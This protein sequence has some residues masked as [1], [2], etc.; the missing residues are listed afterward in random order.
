[1]YKLLL[2]PL[3]TLIGFTAVSQD[4][5]GTVPFNEAKQTFPQESKEAFENW[6]HKR[7]QYKKNF[8]INS[9]QSDLV[10]TIPVVVHV[11]HQGESIGT[12]S[13]IPD[14]QI[15]S[16]IQ[17][18][19][20]D[21]RRTNE[22]ANDTPLDFLPFAAD[23]RIEFKLAVRDPE[24]LP[25]NGINRVRGSRDDYSINQLDDLAHESYWD[26][27][28]YFNI[29]VSDLSNDYIGY[30][31]FPLSNLVGLNIEQSND[32]LTDG[33]FIDYQY[34]GTGY[35]TDDFSRGRTVTHEVGHWLGLRHI[36][37]DASNC[38]ADD[39]CDDTPLQQSSTNPNM[40]C[41][42]AS[43]SFSCTTTDMTQNYMDY[44][45]DKCMNLFTLDQKE[46]MRTV[47]ENS[48]RRTVL[49]TSPALQE[50]VQVA[51]D[52]GIYQIIEP[53]SGN[54]D[55]NITPTLQVKNYGTNAITSFDV[56]LK[57]DGVII[58]T[59]SSSQN[60][61]LLETAEIEFDPYAV[62]NTSS[63]FE[64]LVTTVNGGSDGNSGNNSRTVEGYFPDWTTIPLDQD[65]TNSSMTGSSDWHIIGNWSYGV[66][67]DESASNEAAILSYA[68]S[69]SDQLGTLDYLISPAI[70]LIGIA[71]ADLNFDYAFAAVPGNY[72]DGL[73][74]IVST[75]C[76]N[77]FPVE[78]TLFSQLAPYLGTTSQSSSPFSPSGLGDWKNVELNLSSYTN[79]D[80]IVLAFVGQN[81]NGNNI[82][83]DNIHITTTSVTNHDAL[84]KS[85]NNIPVVSC[86]SDFQANIEV[87]NNGFSNLTSF[88]VTGKVGKITQSKEVDQV[89]LSPGQNTTVTLL[90]E[91]I[92]AG[93][94]S[95]DFNVSSPNGQN[96]ELPTNDNFSQYFIVN[97]SVEELPIKIDFLTK[98]PYELWKKYSSSNLQ[99]WELYVN[100][101]DDRDRSMHYNAFDNINLGLVNQF[102]SPVLDL[103]ELD[104]AAMRFDYS[105]AYSTGRNDR[106]Q[107]LLSTD[108]GQSFDEVL[109][110]KN[111]A[112]LAVTETS[113]EWFPE[114]EEDW[115][116]E[117]LD[118][119]AYTGM[120][121]IRLSFSFTNQHGNNLFLDNIEF[122]DVAAP[123]NIDLDGKIRIYPNPASDQFN[124]KIN[125]YEKQNAIIR[126]I[127]MNGE[128][129]MEQKIDNVLNQV[130]LIDN[131]SLRSGIY[132]LQ[133]I[134]DH[135]RASS[136]V[137]INR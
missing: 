133:V 27:N 85:V 82:Y 111:G 6:M 41:S 120:S 102:V 59:L 63:L 108:C 79:L 107:V 21:F 112:G 83:L 3:L 117:T 119:S 61:N 68:G 73:A 64:F 91:D 96:D 76:G 113:S 39:Y 92:E 98:P 124:V 74:V 46:R 11:V 94:W 126:L 54:C 125:F 51:N 35:N 70:S 56:Q 80:E 25:T 37:G 1:M 106:L 109:F 53:S 128:V 131:L 15:I 118:L 88:K 20:E 86:L 84:I 127:N 9:T 69:S 67:A 116:T 52:L 47:I 22:D 18:M 16:Q 121:D 89:N 30:A 105:Y 28:Q 4:R 33:V 29:W 10:Y 110:D 100:P 19:N 57:V 49:L 2:Y 5:C 134:G 45:A 31:Q 104:E 87:R 13:N 58:Q 130:Y 36:W 42:E 34:F 17:T 95:A 7:I 8:R 103:S 123:D 114:S 77:T 43:I 12:A 93:E 50:V 71:T 97:A 72:T 23:T 101:S 129:L 136:R 75:D 66:A 40:D 122:F 78:N 48:P 38:S 26:A 99:Y 135:D 44:T 115:I 60:L 65:F 24:G 132:I 62:N 137:M 55:K 32:A 81:G 90:F 14:E